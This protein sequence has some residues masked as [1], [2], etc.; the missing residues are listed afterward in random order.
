MKSTEF[1][2]EFSEM[3]LLRWAVLLITVSL[4][5]KAE[6]PG[7]DQPTIY[8]FTLTYSDYPHIKI[9]ALY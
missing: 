7:S 1:M 2:P 9:S 6:Q 5:Q 3:P 4:L 8:A